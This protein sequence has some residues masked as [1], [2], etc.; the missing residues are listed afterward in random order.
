LAL[1]A[2]PLIETSLPRA[3][4]ATLRH[5]PAERRSVLHLLHA[6]PVLRGDLEG[7]TV[8]VI[9]DITPLHNTHVSIASPHPVRAARLVPLGIPLEITEADGRVQFTVPLIEGHQMIELTER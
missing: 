3:G 6:N 7:D 4:R 5:Q 1:G 8:Q 9:Q 2:R